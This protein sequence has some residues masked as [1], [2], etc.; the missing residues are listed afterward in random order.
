M[1]KI[2]KGLKKKKKGKK[3]KHK[4]EEL[5]D[6]AE[7][8]E[9]ERYK[10]EKQQKLA[11][12]AE[13]GTSEG[14]EPAATSPGE[15]EEWE[16]FKALTS[17]VDDILKKTQ[18]D[19][20]RIKSTSY[21]QKKPPGP[22][23][24]PELAPKPER[25]SVGPSPAKGKW[26]G[27]SEGGEEAE[28]E[29]ETDVKVEVTPAAGGDTT[30]A[31]G[32]GNFEEEE[33]ESEFEDDADDLF[34]TSYVDVVASGEVK[35]AYVPD[36]PEP[37]DDFDPFD[38]SIVD[39]VIKV[40]PAEE[41]KKKLVSL[42]CA[43]EVLT[44]KLDKPVEV[45]PEIV[46]PQRRR[47]R[48]RDL[49]LGSFD[50]GPGVVVEDAEPEPAPRSI[51]DDD[52]VFA[53]ETSEILGLAPVTPVVEVKPISSPLP[54]PKKETPKNQGLDLK[55]LVE[56]FVSFS[57][58]EEVEDTLIPPPPKPPPPQ[59]QS[60]ANQAALSDVDDFNPDED[61]PFDT[62]FA[63]QV[64]PGKF[65]LK[66]IEKEILQETAPVIEKDTQ[67]R[68][69]EVLKN[70]E[71]SAKV[72]DVEE[73]SL[74]VEHKDL[75][76]GSAS[77]LSTLGQLPI[78]PKSLEDFDAAFTADD[79]FD[80]S[81]VEKVVAPG[82]T[83]LKF[84]EKEFLDPPIGIPTNAA[85]PVVALE[86]D[87]FD[88]R[89][90]EKL[91]KPP[92]RPD[93][94]SVA[95]KRVS[96]PKVV[97]FDVDPSSKPDLLAVDQEESSKV[98]KPLTPYYPQPNQA[99]QVGDSGS[100]IDPFDTSY[101]SEASRPGKLE[102]QILEKELS[103]ATEIKRS[104]SDPDFDPRGAEQ[105][106]PVPVSTVVRNNPD[107]LSGENEEELKL[108]TPV[109]PRKAFGDPSQDTDPFDTSIASGLIP[110]KAEI[111]ILESEL[112]Y[113]E[114]PLPTVSNI[115]EELLRKNELAKRARKQSVD[116]VLEQD[117][118]EITV[119]P[120]TPVT[121]GSFDLDDG[122]DPFDTS[123]VEN[124]VPGKTEIKLLESELLS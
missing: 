33:E 7:L 119:K 73:V 49:L 87:D 109:V 20:D 94:L 83:E 47:P 6:P 95:G 23:A 81:V 17:G 18:G 3:G 115:T 24:P 56:E 16:K 112:I 69:H 102:L 29:E 32:T 101:V 116:I 55:T 110:G 31:F 8:A 86:D 92:T 1:L 59:V 26:I 63:A 90:E 2:P 5:F 122:V 51:L 65:E 4:E 84:L 15:N 89:A 96:V 72:N 19:L 106:A 78:A 28:P 54:P 104:L 21:F 66:L 80:T 22:S 27:F 70:S 74:T 44:G 42:G 34:D 85:L 97:A 103:S 41:K 43:V 71:L 88:P 107:I 60:N 93:N 67:S 123:A 82:K 50:E 45:P 124:I 76:G 40:D 62:S 100:D 25:P 36:S 121:A 108:H 37:E 68:I 79:P 120:L 58:T 39:K 52:P 14:G 118:E 46:K 48:P 53:E 99:G 91:E 11:E 111:K 61:D 75:L 77:D 98:S 57:T 30:D 64:L 117:T 113:S 13:A 114:T 38:T 9:L 12:A 105:S 35:L 10:K